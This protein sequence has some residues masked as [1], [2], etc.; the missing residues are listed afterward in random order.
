MG[1]KIINGKLHFA[2]DI[3]AAYGSRSSVDRASR[4]DNVS[5]RNT[6]KKE[7]DKSSSF[8]ISNH[9]AERLKSRHIVLGENDMENINSAINRA[10]E[11]GCRE[12]AL[13]YGNTVLIT[14]IKNRTVITAMN[15]DSDNDSVF[16]NID[17]MVIV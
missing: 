5:F 8:T 15:K 1:Y 6:L 16:T 13:L 17:S 14:S 3:A 9:A 11:K 10:E 2:Q 12:S 7:V 4:R